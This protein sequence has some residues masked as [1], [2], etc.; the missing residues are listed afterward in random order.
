[1]V[2][3][4][5]T[6][7]SRGRRRAELDNQADERFLRERERYDFE[8][9][10]REQRWQD[11]QWQRQAAAYLAPLV[12]NQQLAADAGVGA[13]D[14]L[15]QQRE[16]IIADPNF[17]AMPPEVQSQVLNQL[18]G[19]AITTAQQAQSQGDL[20]L[21]NQLVQAFG[22]FPV[23]SGVDQALLTG[24][25]ARIAEAMNQ[26]FGSN[27]QIDADGMVDIGGVRVPAIEAIR[28]ATAAGSPLGALGTAAAEQLRLREESQLMAARDLARQEQQRSFDQ[29]MALIPGAYRGEDG[30]WRLNGQVVQPPSTGGAMTAIGASAVPSAGVPTTAASA[31]PVGSETT[32]APASVS[33]VAQAAGQAQAAA[34]REAVDAQLASLP[35]WA[36]SIGNIARGLGG[37]NPAPLASLLG[38]S[39]REAPSAVEQAAVAQTAALDPEGY[40]AIWA[41]GAPGRA[42]AADDLAAAAN[43]YGDAYLREVAGLEDRVTT[44][45]QALAD[46]L[47]RL[48]GI[49]SSIR[50]ATGQTSSVQ[51]AAS[52]IGRLQA[53]LA[54][55]LQRQAAPTTSA[56]ERERLRREAVQLREQIERAD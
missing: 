44:P 18:R 27:L 40:S 32:A 35:E 56:T 24:D 9:A 53:Q 4:D 17:Q 42:A 23:A 33:E 3:I 11:Q 55:N 26:Q 49:Q 36:R 20:D 48:P 41:T 47:G 10:G 12:G 52:E 6:A 51:Q 50:Q 37:A 15:L 28:A 7:L 46:L 31:A 45:L 38:I 30:F 21:A 43:L 2:D 54:Q 25:P 16:Q 39:P 1:M 8:R 34:E 19:S 22:N 13:A 29:T 14:F 5:F